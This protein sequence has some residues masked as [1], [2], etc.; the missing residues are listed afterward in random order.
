[1]KNSSIRQQV[2]ENKKKK[3]SPFISNFYHDI[4]PKRKQK[5]QKTPE[6]I[7]KAYYEKQ[8]L[9]VLFE[10]KV[11]FFKTSSLITI[12]SL[13][14]KYD[15]DYSLAFRLYKGLL[16]R[17]SDEIRD[18]DALYED[19]PELRSAN[20][21]ELKAIHDTNLQTFEQ[22][23]K[24]QAAIVVD[25]KNIDT[26]RHNIDIESVRALSV[27]RKYHDEELKTRGE[28]TAIKEGFIYLIYHPL[29]EGWIKAGMTVDY[30]MRLKTYNTGD[31]LCRYTLVAVSH[32]TDR[33]QSEVNLLAKLRETNEE[34]QGEW[35]KI[36]IEKAIGVFNGEAQRAN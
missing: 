14:S 29:F 23:R 17:I 15:I 16:N 6:Q 27:I 32:V 22:F 34:M 36:N 24:Q 7:K 20:H 31:P 13:Q 26:V 30:E 19:K 3:K 35:F 21:D 10:E 11:E 25:N 1:M 8:R 12:D 2:K 4:K 18:R 33:R 28:Q 9:K 5:P